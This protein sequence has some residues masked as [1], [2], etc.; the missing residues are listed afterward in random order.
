MPSM[1]ILQKK[2]LHLDDKSKFKLFTDILDN[3]NDC[4]KFIA[5]S[6]LKCFFSFDKYKTYI[7]IYYFDGILD[8]RFWWC[9]KRQHYAITDTNLQ[10]QIY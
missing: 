10:F 9:P 2:A 4:Q 1:V 7:F 3:S 6:I 8:Q 5:T